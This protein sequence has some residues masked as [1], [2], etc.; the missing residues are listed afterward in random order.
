MDLA[1]IN[2]SV[3]VGRNVHISAEHVQLGDD[4][5][6]GDDV[7]IECRRLVLRHG[8]RLEARC[9]VGGMRGP[10]DFID[11]GEQSLIAH[12][13]KLLCP[14][15]VLGDYVA[16]HNHTLMNGRGPLLIGHNCWIGQHCI[17]NSEASLSIGNSVC[18]GTN[19]NLYSHGYFG[20]LLEGCQVFKVVPVTIEDDAWIMGS[21]T[22]VAPGVRV[23]EKALVLAG[24]CVTKDVPPNHCFGGTPARD[25]TDRLV[26]YRHVTPDEKL[27]RIGEF[28][29]EYVQTVFP[30]AFETEPNGYVVRAPFGPFRLRWQPDVDSAACL[31]SDI[32]L[33]VFTRRNEAEAPPDLVTVFDLT[34]RQY[35]RRRTPAEISTISFLKSYRARFVPAD[36]PR[37]ELP[38]EFRKLGK[39]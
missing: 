13:C 6:I 8:A 37:V 34:R 29:A 30:A 39:P 9:V 31:A 23:G 15:A 14:A 18:V 38:P 26:P 22:S 10:A 4:V 35:T 1:G 2:P 7:R 28:L 20:D 19:T 32:P 17:L 24:S 36:R 25:M 21:Y 16:I 3:R 33:L 11:I 12:D 5:C 27:A